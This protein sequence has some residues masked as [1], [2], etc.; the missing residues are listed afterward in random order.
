MARFS[1]ARASSSRVAEVNRG[2]GALSVQS[3]GLENVTASPSDQGIGVKGQC[4]AV[5]V[6]SLAK[7][8]LRFRKPASASSIRPSLKSA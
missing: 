1:R 5:E 3:G 4:N 2:N 6:P 7:Q 8:Q